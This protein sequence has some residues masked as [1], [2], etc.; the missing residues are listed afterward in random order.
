MKKFLRYIIDD[1]DE[2]IPVLYGPP[3]VYIP[4]KF[5]VDKKNIVFDFGG[6]LMRHNIEGCKEAF[7]QFMS[8]EDIYNVLGIGNKEGWTLL[9]RFDAGYLSKYSFVEQLLKHCARG[10]TNK[11]IIDALN[12]MH[13]GIP[14]GTW[15]KLRLLK[16]KGF[17]LYLMS[18]TNEIHWEH[19]QS[20]YEDLIDEC[21]EDV[22]LSFKMDCAKPDKVF[23]KKVDSAIHADPKQ[24]YF[25]DDLEE[26]RHAAKKLVKWQTCADFKELIE[27]L[28]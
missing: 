18:N 6:V 7:R 3:P 14:E 27:K 21:F 9:R 16:R 13:A 4:R 1:I 2:P 24:T 8:D 10:T 22:F 15:M 17:H 28:K 20:L 25:V 11:M 12:V 5:I 26:N 23:Y 19:T